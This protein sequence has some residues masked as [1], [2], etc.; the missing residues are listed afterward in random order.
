MVAALA[1][2]LTSQLVDSQTAR[3]SAFPEASDHP[4]V[5]I[6]FLA[7]SAALDHL[8][9]Y[10]GSPLRVLCPKLSDL[11]GSLGP[12]LC[13]ACGALCDGDATWA[14][15]EEF[16]THA[17]MTSELEILRQELDSALQPMTT[18]RT[19]LGPSEGIRYDRFQYAVV[20]TIDDLRYHDNFNALE[21]IRLG[22][23]RFQTSMQQAL[24][25]R[26]QALRGVDP[27]DLELS[28]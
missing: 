19:S 8:L 4:V 24:V 10:E 27:D 13:D 23:L 25:S 9:L 1:L 18:W 3:N 28:Q 2:W 20:V 16:P 14:S 26:H 22:L 6:G 11:A 15:G 7:M 21:P 17:I 5:A 12:M